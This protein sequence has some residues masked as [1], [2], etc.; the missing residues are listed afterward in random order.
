MAYAIFA[1]RL[2]ILPGYRPALDVLT[3]VAALPSMG[4]ARRKI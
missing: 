3:K 2:N 1:F 4:I